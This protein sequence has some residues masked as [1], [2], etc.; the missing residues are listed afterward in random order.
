MTSCNDSNFQQEVDGYANLIINNLPATDAHLKEIQFQQNEDPVCQKL[1]IYCQEGW[2]DNSTLKGPFKPYVA[3]ASGLCVANDLLL[4][5]SQ[6]V[7]PPKLRTDILNK[8]YTGYQGIAK[9][10]QQML[11]SVWWPCITKDLEDL[12]SK[13]PI[14]CMQ[15][16]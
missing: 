7:I 15:K 1:K 16:L 2:P 6:L 10:Q 8:I 13:C 4:R 9:C 3:V 5:G 12:I 11:Q 14:C